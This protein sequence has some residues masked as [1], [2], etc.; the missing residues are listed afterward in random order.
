MLPP[1]NKIPRHDVL[2]YDTL[3][4]ILSLTALR[5]F[6]QLNMPVNESFVK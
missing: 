3:K 4:K 5:G 6:T 1:E 2:G